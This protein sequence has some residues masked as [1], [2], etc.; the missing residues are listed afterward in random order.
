MALPLQLLCVLVVA[1][2]DAPATRGPFGPH[3]VLMRPSR[4]E[5]REEG[6]RHDAIAWVHCPARVLGDVENAACVPRMYHNEMLLVDVHPAESAS[7]TKSELGTFL[8]FQLPGG[9][10]EIG[11]LRA[12]CDPC[13]GAGTVQTAVTSVVTG[14]PLPPGAPLDADTVRDSIARANECSPVDHCWEWVD[15]LRHLA[16]PE[17]WQAASRIAERLFAQN[18]S[19]PA[20]LEAW[21]RLK[22]ELGSES[23]GMRL[24]WHAQQLQRPW[25]NHG[26]SSMTAIAG[27]A[28]PC[29]VD[30]RD[31]R[32]GSS[33]PVLHELRDVTL[34]RGSAPRTVRLVSPA[35]RSMR[36]RCAA[37]PTPTSSCPKSSLSR[38]S[39]LTRFG[40]ALRS[41]RAQ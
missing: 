26:A 16:V 9:S 31:E 36:S 1:G 21:A 29:S 33:F 14:R 39:S 35:A 19:H 8:A 7:G 23:D 28:D 22:I 15:V 30:V 20:L 37:A 2:A 38:I 24:L 40:R 34:T 12:D 6:K 5:R 11:A 32:I 17:A 25:T 18:N 10:D 27:H 4:H 13:S 3:V 41:H